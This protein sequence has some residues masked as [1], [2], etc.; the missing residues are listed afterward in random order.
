MSSSSSS[1]ESDD[2]VLD[3]YR[4]GGQT[5]SNPK[6]STSDGDSARKKCGVL[7]NVELLCAAPIVR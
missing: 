2:C 3:L 4:R 5:M 1:S 7:T 6:S